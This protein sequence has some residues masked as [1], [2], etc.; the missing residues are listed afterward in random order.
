MSTAP[1][2]CFFALAIEPGLQ[3]FDRGAGQHQS[4]VIENVVYVRADR[5]QQIDLAQIGRS[6]GEA[7]IDRVA[8]DH[9]RRLAEA[10]LAELLLKRAG[11]GLLQIEAV[12]D[13]D[14][15]ALCLSG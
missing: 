8:V 3:L 11:L 13:D 9:Q 1:P 14:V 15:A 5:R 6:V 7:D 10:E 4:L 12:E 2:A